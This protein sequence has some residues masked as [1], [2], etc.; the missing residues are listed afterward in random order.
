MGVKEEFLSYARILENLP[1]KGMEIL[2]EGEISYL[3]FS[4]ENN[5]NSS[6]ILLGKEVLRG[7]FQ[8]LTEIFTPVSGHNT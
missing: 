3:K 2:D 7:N 1:W 5:C 6:P 4:P 8:I